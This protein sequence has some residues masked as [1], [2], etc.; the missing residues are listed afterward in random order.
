M[1]LLAPPPLQ[2]R[3][4]YRMDYDAGRGGYGII[5]QKEVE[6]SMLASCRCTAAV[7]GTAVLHPRA[8]ALPSLCPPCARSACCR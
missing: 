2:V 4:E 7:G 3:D 6:V 1:L 8:D 5:L